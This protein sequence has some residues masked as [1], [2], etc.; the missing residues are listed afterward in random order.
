M[1]RSQLLKDAKQLALRFTAKKVRKS[2][3]DPKIGDLAGA[4][5]ALNGIWNDDVLAAFVRDTADF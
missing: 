3:K 1:L 2:M 5:Y 4:W